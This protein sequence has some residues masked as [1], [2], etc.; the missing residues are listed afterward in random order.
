MST[1]E[2]ICLVLAGL[3]IIFGGAYLTKFKLIIKEL[4]ELLL[5]LENALHDDKI[6]K[7]EWENIGKEVYDII[8]IFTKKNKGE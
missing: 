8:K 6:T 5:V 2:I 4:K 7:K 3:G 1:Y